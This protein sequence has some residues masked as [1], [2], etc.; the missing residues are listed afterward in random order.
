LKQ[1]RRSKHRLRALDTSK[2]P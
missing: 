2:R 1:P